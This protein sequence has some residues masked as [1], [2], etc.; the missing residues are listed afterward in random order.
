MGSQTWR[1]A[2]SEAARAAISGPMP[3]GSPAVMATRG[4]P[5]TAAG[6]ALAGSTAAR[7]TAG[8]VVASAF[9]AAAAVHDALGVR[10][11]VAQA[12]FQAAAESRQLRR[13]QAQVLLLRHLV[14]DRLEGLQERRAAQRTPAGAVAADHLGFVADADLAHLDPRAEF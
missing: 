12:A 14:R 5:M 7:T 8:W 3:A 9:V 1:T 4:L 13:I 11:L 6:S 2:G 10:Q